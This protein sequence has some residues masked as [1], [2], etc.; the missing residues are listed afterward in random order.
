MIT[1]TPLGMPSRIPSP[2]QGLPRLE[3][4][5]SQAHH[6]GRKRAGT[7]ERNGSGR[8]G[9][10][11]CPTEAGNQH[12]CASVLPYSVYACQWRSGCR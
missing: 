5:E 10:S 11:A 8:S 7:E 2:S 9:A 6:D 3:G 12:R 1:P 4:K